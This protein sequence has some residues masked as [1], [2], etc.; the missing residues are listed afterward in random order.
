MALDYKAWLKKF[1]PGGSSK[2]T[3]QTGAAYKRWL[4]KNAAHGSEG[5]RPGCRSEARVHAAELR[6]A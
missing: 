5:R 4:A 3:A 6:R 2:S 1:T